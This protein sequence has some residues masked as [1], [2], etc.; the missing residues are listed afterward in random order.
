MKKKLFTF[1]WNLSEFTGIGLG[2]FAPYVFERMLGITRKEN[3]IKI[4]VWFIPFGKVGYRETY[5][6]WFFRAWRPGENAVTYGI[7]ILG[8]NAYLD[9]RKI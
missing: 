9:L 7:G 1:I 5:G 6:Q 3:K 2:R 8:L 4:H